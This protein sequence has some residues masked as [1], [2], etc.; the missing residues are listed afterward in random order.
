MWCGIQKERLLTPLENRNNK[1][2]PGVKG[3]QYKEKA[4]IGFDGTHVWNINFCSTRQT[5]SDFLKNCR[6]VISQSSWWYW[7]SQEYPTM[8]LAVTHLV[9]HSLLAKRLFKFSTHHLG[10]KT[11]LLPRNFGTKTFSI[12]I[13]VVFWLPTIPPNLIFGRPTPPP[14]TS[15]PA[16]NQA[17]SILPLPLLSPKD[18]LLNS[19]KRPVP[20]SI[21]VECQ[22]V[23]VGI[24]QARKPRS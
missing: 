8:G 6:L 14:P 23:V 19:S 13:I 18:P 4:R 15:H 9:Y 20:K 3:I 1:T 24:W 12:K 2:L 7:Y 17:P 11:L 10:W 21:F 22:K 16:P 5:L